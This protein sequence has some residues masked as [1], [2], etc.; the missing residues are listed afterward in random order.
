MKHIYFVAES[1]GTLDTMKFNHITPTEHAK[2]DYAQAHFK[3][4]STDDVVYSVV[5]SYQALLEKVMK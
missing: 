3:A 1:K 4:I 2:I 5:D